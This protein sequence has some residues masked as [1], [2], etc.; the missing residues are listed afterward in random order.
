M[1][2]Y[3]VIKCLNLEAVDSGGFSDPYVVLSI[4]SEKFFKSK[5]MKKNL[6][7]TF[8]ETAITKVK[9]KKLTNLLVEVF[10]YNKIQ[11]HVSL[12]S[13]V[14]PINSLNHGVPM[15]EEYPLEK[16][17]CGSILLSLQFD[18]D[19][20]K[21]KVKSSTVKATSQPLGGL[22]MPSSKANE[23]LPKIF[24]P[25]ADDESHRSLSGNSVGKVSITE[26]VSNISPISNESA[27]RRSKSSM[28][29]SIGVFIFCLVALMFYPQDSLGLRSRASSASA[30]EPGQFS[31]YEGRRKRL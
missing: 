6:N 5:T 18:E 19:I 26:S 22:R 9:S 11:K 17:R 28:F 21:K 4:G 20:S 15:S 8:N 12:G 7:P 24:A 3:I 16:A 1:H 10:D 2:Y 31:Q 23:K 29:G 27:V 25:P 30:V 13:V 14:I